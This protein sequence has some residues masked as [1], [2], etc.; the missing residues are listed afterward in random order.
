[1]AVPSAPRVLTAF[2]AAVAAA[3][4]LAA[5]GPPASAQL[6]IRGNQ[7]TIC[8][9]AQAKDANQVVNA[10]ERA[11]V[12]TCCGGP[13]VRCGSVLPG[14]PRI[15]DFSVR[16]ELRR[17]ELPQPIPLTAPGSSFLLPGK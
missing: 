4:T 1:M 15:A 17:P 7:L 12:R 9:D 3:A 10:G 8:A 13:S 14:G 16:A 11:V 2:F 5:N 6:A